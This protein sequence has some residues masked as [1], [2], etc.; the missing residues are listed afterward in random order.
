MLKRFSQTCRLL[1]VSLM[2]IST[3]LLSVSDLQA[4]EL[5]AAPE[6]THTAPQ[7]WLNSK[8]LKLTDLRGKV[9]LLDIWTFDCWNCYRSFPWLNDLS[10]HYAK[11]G[12]QLIGVHSPEF[13]HERDTAALAQKLREFNI[14]SPQMIDNDFSY[15]K[16]LGNKYWPAFYLID[17][18]GLVQAQ[19]I[20]ETHAGDAKA[21]EI[22]A[23]IVE[24]LAE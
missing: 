22:E 11:Q 18:Y 12:L 23:K 4:K 8:P 3:S 2:L 24:L 19:Y 1:L 13:A 21:K 17:K 20:G 10:E 14:T 7:E 5:E 15:W 9:V 6:F 16:A